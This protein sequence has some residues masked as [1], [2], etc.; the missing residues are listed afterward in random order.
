MGEPTLW[1]GGFALGLSGVRLPE[2]VGLEARLRIKGLTWT[3]D[4]QH[5]SGECTQD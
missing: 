5:W 3:C 1:S 2:V 4:A